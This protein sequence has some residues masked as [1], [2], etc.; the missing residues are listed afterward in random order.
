[1]IPYAEHPLTRVFISSAQAKTYAEMRQALAL[2]DTLSR[3]ESEQVIAA[4]KLAAEVFLEH[5]HVPNGHSRY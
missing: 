1:M 3:G 2:I 5:N 4:C